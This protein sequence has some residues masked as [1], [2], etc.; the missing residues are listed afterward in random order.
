VVRHL[1]LDYADPSSFTDLF[2]TGNSYNRG[3]WSNEEYDKLVDASGNK[4]A[5]DEEAR[6]EDLQ[7]A[8]EQRP[9]L[10]E[11]PVT[12]KSVKLDGSA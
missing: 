4:D 2:V 12:N 9:R 5:S 6:W 10:Y 1:I 8:N 3:R 7:K 11:F